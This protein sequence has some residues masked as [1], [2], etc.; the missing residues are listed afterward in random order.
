MSYVNNSAA[1]LQ[2]L[3]I[4]DTVPV[5]S[6]FVSTGLETTPTKLTAC[7][8]STPANPPPAAEVDCAS[9]QGAGGVGTIR[10]RFVGQLD[11]AAR[12][13]ILFRV[14]VD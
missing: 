13:A 5:F 9:P 1:S 2:D 8:K 14:K 11:P 4:N 6:T 12:G 3:T 7:T 10:W